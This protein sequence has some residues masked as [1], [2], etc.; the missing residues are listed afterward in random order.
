MLEAPREDHMPI[1]PIRSRGYL[2]ERHPHLE[3]NPGFFR[4]NPDRPDIADSSNHLV[5]QRSNL[6]PFPLEVMGE[7]VPAARM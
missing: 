7:V 1:K 3:G 2:R 4:Q 5:E 6:G